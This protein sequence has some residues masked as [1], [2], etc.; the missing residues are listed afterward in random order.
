M[1]DFDLPIVNEA[2]ER[3]L[4]TTIN[5]ALREKSN[6]LIKTSSIY[7]IDN[8]EVVFKTDIGGYLWASFDNVSAESPSAIRAISLSRSNANLPLISAM[9]SFKGNILVFS[10]C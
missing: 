4:V 6:L 3:L 10:E 9:S 5:R 1:F 7:K 8:N 2:K